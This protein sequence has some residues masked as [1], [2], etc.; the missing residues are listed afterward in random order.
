MGFGIEG[1]L[2][3][4]VGDRPIRAG[5]NG[6]V[7]REGG[8]RVTSVMVALAWAVLQQPEDKAIARALAQTVIDVSEKE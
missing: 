6:A 5:V 7:S 8:H 3:G 2:G 4:P 1:R